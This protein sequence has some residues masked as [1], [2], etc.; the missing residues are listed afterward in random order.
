[1]PEEG[2][3]YQIT[4]PRDYYYIE[5]WFDSVE[6]SY[7]NEV[8]AVFK[9]DSDAKSRASWSI[10]AG[11]YYE[12]VRLLAVAHK[13]AVDPNV[14]GERDR[15]DIGK[16][17]KYLEGTGCQVVKDPRLDKWVRVSEIEPGEVWMIAELAS[18]REFTHEDFFLSQVLAKNE[19][20]AQRRIGVSL[21]ESGRWSFLRLWL[22]EDMPVVRDVNKKAPKVLPLD[23]VRQFLGASPQTE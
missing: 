19:G 22:S 18:W 21:A 11:S 1:M 15:V 12:M 7:S 20:Q 13:F 9:A 3:F 14:P 6:K 8:R 16:L 23:M 10:H 5:M 4:K 2:L 17:L